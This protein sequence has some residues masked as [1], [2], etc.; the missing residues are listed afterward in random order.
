MRAD[1]VAAGLL[2]EIAATELAQR[3]PG[4]PAGQAAEPIRP[5]SVLLAAEAGE[6]IIERVQHTA[7]WQFLVVDEEG[8]PCGVLHRDDL[9]AAL[10]RGAG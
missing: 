1:G 10:D 4:A 2:D 6:D 8:R 7:A 3:S 9:R 5:E